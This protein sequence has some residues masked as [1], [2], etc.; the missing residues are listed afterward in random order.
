MS[1][2]QGEF[3]ETYR[4]C[5]IWYYYAGL[6]VSFE[7]WDT[8]CVTATYFQSL[9][10][11][12]DG[13]DAELGPVVIIPPD[14]EPYLEEVYEDVEIW[15]KPTLNT[16]W[17]Q[18]APG[19]VAVDANLSD[20]RLS[21]DGILEFLN[22]PEDPDAGLFAQIVAALQVWVNEVLGDSLQPIY[23]LIDAVLAAAGTYADDLFTA[24]GTLIDDV[25]AE[26]ASLAAEVGDQWD[27]FT[28][29]TLPGILEDI[30]AK[31]AEIEEAIDTKI[32]EF[33]EA[34]DQGFVDMSTYIDKKVAALDTVDFFEDPPKYISGIFAL[35]GLAKE[36]GM[37]ESFLAGLLEG[38]EE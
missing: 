1:K 5:S 8:P 19:Y 7:V 12:R 18:V 26:L 2:P 33:Q 36:T 24:A 3:V 37:I 4:A 30:E 11:C 28:T 14:E 23:D 15:W 10:N 31:A 16:F 25:S 9:Q 34:I 21:I 22:P 29:V 20:I 6:L 17:A 32:A 35:L 38:L 27:N 13:I